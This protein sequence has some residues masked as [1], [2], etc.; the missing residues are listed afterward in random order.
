MAS[1]LDVTR[2]G[3]K[4]RHRKDQERGDQGKKVKDREPRRLMARMAGLYRSKKLGKGI[5]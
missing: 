3:E 5:P 4:G 2:R 1:R